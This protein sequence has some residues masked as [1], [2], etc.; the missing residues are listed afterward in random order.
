MENREIERQYAGKVN[1][2]VSS[3]N[4]F[5]PSRFFLHEANERKNGVPALN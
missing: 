1:V 4:W 2:N 3:A 5:C